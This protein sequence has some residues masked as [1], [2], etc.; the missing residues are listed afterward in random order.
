MSAPALIRALSTIRFFSR[1]VGPAGL[2]GAGFFSA[3]SIDAAPVGRRAAFAAG[4]LVFLGSCAG[5]TG[6]ALARGLGGGLLL[7]SGDD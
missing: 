7:A 5:R 3:A 1:S 4:L 2:A 6:R